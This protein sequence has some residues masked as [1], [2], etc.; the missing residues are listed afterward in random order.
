MR[1]TI[2]KPSGRRAV[3]LSLDAALVKEAK[4]LGVNLSQACERGLAR[5]LKAAREARWK[6]ETARRS[7]PPMPGWRST[8]C[9]SPDI[10]CSRVARFDVHRLRD[11]SGVVL[12]RQADLLSAFRTRFV[13]PLVPCGDAPKPAIDR[14]NPSLPVEGR[15]HIMVTQF[16]GSVPRSDLGPVVASLTGHDFEIIR[17]IDLLFQRHVTPPAPPV[18]ETP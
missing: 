11:G 12:D 10:A 4:A 5:E 1:M 2:H 18:R 7:R 6:E 13:V 3:N 14:L 15:A 8:G 16:A 9:R 17:A